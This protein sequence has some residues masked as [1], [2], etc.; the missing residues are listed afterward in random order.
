MI[1]F[2]ALFEPPSGI[3]VDGITPARFRE[4]LAASEQFPGRLFHY[5]ENGVQRNDFVDIRFGKG[6]G[7]APRVVAIG[8]EAGRDLLP[9]V[10]QIAR[11][12]GERLGNGKDFRPQLKTGFLGLRQSPYLIEYFIP[13]LAFQQHQWVYKKFEVDARA[14]TASPDMIHYIHK[15]ILAGIRRQAQ[16]AGIEGQLDEIQIVLGDITIGNIHPVDIKKDRH[17]LVT[18]G[19]AFRSNIVFEGPWSCGLLTARGYGEILR[20]GGRA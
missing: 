1:W 5:H 20:K 18:R 17:C 4:T 6:K 8:D 10:A 15:R 2:E 19:V 11:V 12:A 14:N 9:M 7:R 3:T 16:Y 13:K